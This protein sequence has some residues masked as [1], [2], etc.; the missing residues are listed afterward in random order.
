MAAAAAAAVSRVASAQ[1]SVDACESF[2]SFKFYHFVSILCG[3]AIEKKI[4]KIIEEKKRNVIDA[5]VH[6]KSRHKTFFFLHIKY[7]HQ[8]RKFRVTV[9]VFRSKS[10]IE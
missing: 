1:E 10:M 3:E 9:K 2:E 5:R 7:R 8:L 4:W 6:A